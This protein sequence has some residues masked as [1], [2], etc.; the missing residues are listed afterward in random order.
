ME[1]DEARAVRERAAFIQGLRVDDVLSVRHDA[2]YV[3]QRKAQGESGDKAREG[4]FGCAACLAAT[5]Q[6]GAVRCMGGWQTQRRRR[7]GAARP[8]QAAPVNV[9]AAFDEF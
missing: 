6:Q 4:R 1:P 9:A 7:R 2:A 5:R 3:R 8:R